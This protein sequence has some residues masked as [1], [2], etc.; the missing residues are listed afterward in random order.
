MKNWDL[1]NVLDPA[2]CKHESEHTVLIYIKVSEIMCSK[3]SR[4]IRMVL[5]VSV[6]FSFEFSSSSRYKRNFKIHNKTFVVRGLIYMREIKLEKNEDILK[7]IKSSNLSCTMHVQRHANAS[8]HKHTH[9]HED[10]QV[11]LIMFNKCFSTLRDQ[12]SSIKDI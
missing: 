2:Q 11:N 7:C 10:A 1:I 3:T 5:S 12:S 4:I 9:A 6:F 8:T